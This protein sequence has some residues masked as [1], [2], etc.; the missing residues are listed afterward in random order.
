MRTKATKRGAKYVIDGHKMWISNAMEADLFLVFANAAPE[1]G[2]K[3]ITCFA[4]D[5]DMGVKVSSPSTSPSCSALH[6]TL[7]HALMP[8]P[9]PPAHPTLARSGVCACAP[10][11]ART[12]CDMLVRLAWLASP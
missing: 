7:A 8:H 3:G 10:S 4:V 5:R 6:T 11:R 12:W 9:Q 2:Y 1:L